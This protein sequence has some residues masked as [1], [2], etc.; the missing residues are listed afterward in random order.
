M[1]NA[2]Y[3]YAV[4]RIRAN[5]QKLLSKSDYEQLISAPD[6]ES[7]VRLIADKGWECTEPTEAEKELVSAWELIRQCVT[8]TTAIDALI[9]QND[10]ANLKAVIKC[11]FSDIEP[12]QYMTG[13][14]LTDPALII[15]AVK[16]KSFSELPKHLAKCAKEAYESYVSY[17][18]GQKCEIIIDKAAYAERAGRA[19][20]SGIPLLK[21]IT[22]IQC[23][24]AVVKTALRCAMTGKSREFT[25]EAVV[26]CPGID[27]NGLIDNVS[28]SESIAAFISGT[29]YAEFS[30]SIKRGF[31][32]F[33]AQ[34]DEKIVSMLAA[35]KSEVFSPDPLI[36][37][38]VRKSY[39]V[40]NVRLIL[41]A[42]SNGVSSDEL[43]LKV[44][45]I[46]V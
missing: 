13:P 21:D 1:N 16:T 46:N 17:E 18:S 11:Y 44:R 3:A 22:G 2:D 40:R 39:E 6:K 41:S 8:D 42:K 34:C 43:R 33:E 23:F 10:F 38:W 7:V 25:E 45:G 27:I 5:E 37:F 19:S 36:A 20:A 29:T 26:P 28:S 30:D 12:E 24:E 4:G 32:E 9:V 31:G 14:F 15:N 35:S